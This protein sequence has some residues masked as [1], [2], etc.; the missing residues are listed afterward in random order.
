MRADSDNMPCH[1]GPIIRLDKRFY[2]SGVRVVR[3][4]REVRG[5]AAAV[6]DRVRMSAG[7]END[8]TG[9]SA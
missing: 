7:V 1:A 2:S 5:R 8:V 3:K 9:Y 4:V 6:R